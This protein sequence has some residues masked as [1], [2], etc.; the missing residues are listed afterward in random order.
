LKQWVTL[1]LLQLQDISTAAE[2]ASYGEQELPVSESPEESTAKDS[3]A[4][5]GYSNMETEETPPEPTQSDR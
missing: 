1:K 2:V 4:P 3:G 5:M